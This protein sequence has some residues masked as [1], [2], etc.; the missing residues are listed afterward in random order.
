MCVRICTRRYCSLAHITEGEH[1][2]AAAASLFMPMPM[3]CLVSV[4]VFL[5]GS[6][7]LA[8]NSAAGFQSTSSSGGGSLI[9]QAIQMSPAIHFILERRRCSRREIHQTCTTLNESIGEITSRLD[10]I[11]TCR[12]SLLS[13]ARV[14]ESGKRHSKLF[15]YFT[16]TSVQLHWSMPVYSWMPFP[17]KMRNDVQAC[18]CIFTTEFEKK[19]I[20]F[21]MV[22][23][24]FLA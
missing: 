24:L 15:K 16:P 9:R 20:L 21:L 18:L 13:L 10:L 5:R 19:I 14:C 3:R 2:A 6:T 11:Y 1:M 22:R 4:F 17:N 8:S 7:Q 23:L 12:L